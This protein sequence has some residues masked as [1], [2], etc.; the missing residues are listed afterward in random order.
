MVLLSAIGAFSVRVRAQSRTTS[1]KMA[2]LQPKLTDLALEVA[3]GQQTKLDFSHSSIRNVESILATLHV[4]Q[5]KSRSTDGVFGLALEFGA[6]IITV[7]ER[8]T[9]RGLWEKDHPSF[10]KNAFPF[11]W[12]NSTLF[13]VEWCLKRI[14]DGPEDNVW[15]KYERLVLANLK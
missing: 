2:E 14:V 11:T 12:R 15:V 4:Q 6:Y 3:A 5:H 7:I 10:G 13:P 9:E 8:N 1:G